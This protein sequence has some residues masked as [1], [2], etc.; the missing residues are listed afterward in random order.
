[1]EAPAAAE[2]EDSPE[3]AAYAAAAVVAEVEEVPAEVVSAD[4]QTYRIQIRWLIRATLFITCMRVCALVRC[5]HVF[6][7]E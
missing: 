2:A 7:V 3:V 1:M 4:K 6:G 5:Q